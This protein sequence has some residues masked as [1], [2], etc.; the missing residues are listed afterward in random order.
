V[1]DDYERRCKTSR[2]YPRKKREAPTGAPHIHPATL[3]QITLAKTL[4]KTEIKKGYRR[5]VPP[6][7]QMGVNINLQ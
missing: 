4:K 6:L 3:Q 2:N 1:I 5:S 7:E